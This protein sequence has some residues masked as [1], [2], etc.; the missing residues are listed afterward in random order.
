[1]FRNV[2]LCAIINLSKKI[3]IV[4]VS[5]QKISIISI[6]RL[7]EKWQR[8]AVAEYIKRISAFAKLEVYE[9]AEG[10]L[11]EKPNSAQIDSALEQE[12][13][14]IVK[15]LA[16]L[17]RAEV[18]TLCIEGRQCSSEQLA[19]LFQ[20]AQIDSALEQEAV[21]IVKKLA[22][23]GRAEVCTLCIEGR[24]CS[25]EQLADLFQKNTLSTGHIVFIIGSSHGLADSVKRLSSLRLS[26]SSMTFPHTLARI[27]LTE[28][29]YR[30]LCIN[31]GKRYHK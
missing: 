10:K 27:L 29:I 28:Q 16:T 26:M 25:S 8:E 21:D 23:L 31:N 30:A 18:C 20:T 1:M 4:G 12:A 19:D 17:G 13:V 22:T 7:K 11:P 2:R 3:F 9:L 14:D 6:G 5:L 15:K 24:Q